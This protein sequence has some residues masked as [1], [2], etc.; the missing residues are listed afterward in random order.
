MDRNIKDGLVDNGIKRRIQNVDRAVDK[1][2][3]DD[4]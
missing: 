4:E 1:G 2:K 3:I